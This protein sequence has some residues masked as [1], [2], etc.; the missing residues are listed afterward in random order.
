MKEGWRGEEDGATIKVAREGRWGVTKACVFF[1]QGNPI[2]QLLGDRELQWETIGD[3][4]MPFSKKKIRMGKR[5]RVLLEMLLVS[6]VSDVCIGG[7]EA[8]VH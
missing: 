8:M 2:C 4:F 6:L 1:A 7:L 3:C 5:N